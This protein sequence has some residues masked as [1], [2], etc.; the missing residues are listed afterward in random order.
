MALVGMKTLTSHTRRRK[1]GASVAVCGVAAALTAGCG[2]GGG[3]SSPKADLT[4][5]VRPTQSLATGDTT[6]T[7]TIPG[8]V[9][10]V[11]PAGQVLPAYSG[12][13]LAKYTDSMKAAADKGMQVW[14]ETDLVAPWLSGPDAF[15]AAV[16]QLAYEAKTVPQVVGFKI[17]DELGQSQKSTTTP[18]DALKFLHDARAALHANA[19]GKL[20]AI[21]LIGY[22]LG[23]VPNSTGK[24]HDACVEKNAGLDAR[25]SLDTID[26]IVASGYLDMI[27]VTTYM[28]DPAT[29]QADFKVTRTQA[30]QAAF[31]EVKRRG[32]EKE[33]TVN[34]RKALS[35]P[36]KAPIMDPN[37][38]AAMV[39]DFIDT[40]IQAG[41]AGVD[42]WSW[43]QKWGQSGAV[44]HLMSPNYT[45]NALWDALVQRHAQGDKLYVHYTP[46]YSEGTL[47]QDVDHMSQAFT[48]VFV[49]A[50][51]SSSTTG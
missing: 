12:G 3:K 5:A 49:A 10:P 16:Q 21:D 6:G 18:A 36:T 23:C 37:G 50:G 42:V 26:K 33:I 46:S 17:A 29:Y 34:T 30:Q 1:L 4:P 11:Y 13:D 22:D 27:D 44:V 19:P 32:W 28:L 25:L 47:A 38:A 35:W 14:I 20:I 15:N 48:A 7:P 43:S 2:G 31:D 8:G 9:A 45:T 40:P 24:A 41:A 39:P 51:H